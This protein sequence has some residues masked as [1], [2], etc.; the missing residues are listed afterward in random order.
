MQ[1]QLEAL[2]LSPPRAGAVLAA[3]PPR[4]S[5]GVDDM[6]AG[7][8]APTARALSSAA[9]L[10]QR[11]RSVSSPTAVSRRLLPPRGGL[12]LAVARSNA[13]R[14]E[15][16]AAVGVSGVSGAQAAAASAIRVGSGA[17]TPARPVRAAVGSGAALT[18][19]ATATPEPLDVCVV[20]LSY[21]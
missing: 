2:R 7:V 12:G 10:G 21:T 19:A 11:P 4:H 15:T 17:R 13:S 3:A 5:T 8:A 6:G 14:L 20:E 9:L 18:A 16:M 1:L